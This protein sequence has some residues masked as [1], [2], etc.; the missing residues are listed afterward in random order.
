MPCSPFGGA[1]NLKASHLSP[2][3]CV[4]VDRVTADMD[5]FLNRLTTDMDDLLNR[6]TADMDHF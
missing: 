6:S 1:A 2:A 5:D 4:T 3:P